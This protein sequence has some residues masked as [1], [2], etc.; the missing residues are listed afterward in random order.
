MPGLSHR[1]ISYPSLAAGPPTDGSE[2]DLGALVEVPTVAVTGDVDA[3]RAEADRLAGVPVC[4]VQTDR[5]LAE[6]QRV[7]HLVR[8]NGETSVE[9]MQDPEDSSRMLVRVDVRYD[10]GTLQRRYDEE[11]GADRVVVASLITPVGYTP[12]PS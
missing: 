11:Y 5:P 8:R 4:V 2:P 12:S 10:D 3:A 9:T 7:A 1:Y 6:A